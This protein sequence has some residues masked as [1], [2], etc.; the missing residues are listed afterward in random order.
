MATVATDKRLMRATVL[1]PV[2]LL[3]PACGGAP[4]PLR[5]CEGPGDCRSLVVTCAGCPEQAEVLCLSG[6]CVDA[7]APDV[8]VVGDVSLHRDI[9]AGVR[10]IVH[11]IV[12]VD[13]GTG[14]FRCDE[15][16]DDAELPGWVNVLASGYK[17]VSGGAFHPDVTLGRVP[18][19][20]VAVV[21]FGAAENAGEGA[22]LGVGCVEGLDA[23]TPRLEAGIINVVP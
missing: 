17:S 7:A 10:S 13:T 23:R 4:G 20:D 6:T 11:V 1:L 9:A 18:A 8:D 2:L 5:E 21:V 22:T 15:L 12:A 16:D 3:M 19:G 14:R